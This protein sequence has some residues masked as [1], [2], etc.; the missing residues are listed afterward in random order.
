MVNQVN[1]HLNLRIHQQERQINYSQIP[2]PASTTQTIFEELGFQ[3]SDAATTLK[4]RC[5][6][7]K[8]A[9]ENYQKAK[10]RSI[11][12]KIYTLLLAATTIANIAAAIILCCIP[13]IQFF[14]IGLAII[15][16]ALISSLS[17]NTY[18]NNPG[19]EERTRGIFPK[20]GMPFIAVKEVFTKISRQAVIVDEQKLDVESDFEALSSF[21]TT[22]NKPLNQAIKNAIEEEKRDL[23]KMK[24]NKITNETAKKAIDAKI[25]AL[26]L[27]STDLKKLNQYFIKFKNI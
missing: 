19:I 24:K 20:I 5:K 9:A 14:Y 12:D 3:P 6:T 17:S 15:N 18:K 1:D 4:K 13:P 11:R 21:Y 16:H 7:L 27:A 26:T 22:Q 23:T 10:N 8:S 2:V 25:T